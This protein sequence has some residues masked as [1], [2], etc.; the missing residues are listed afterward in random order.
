M[1]DEGLVQAGFVDGLLERFVIVAVA[2]VAVSIKPARHQH[3]QIAPAALVDELLGHLYHFIN[4]FVEVGTVGE[5]QDGMGGNLRRDKR[6]D[7]LRFRIAV[8]IPIEAVVDGVHPF[9]N[10]RRELRNDRFVGG[11]GVL[12][13]QDPFVSLERGRRIAGSR[14]R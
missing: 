3:A 9:A 2:R 8:E 11:A 1:K 5:E 6:K 4:A 14:D 13:G 12:G 7:R 10:L